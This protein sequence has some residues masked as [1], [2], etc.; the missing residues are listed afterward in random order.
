MSPS[1]HHHDERHHLGLEAD[2][3][4]L[5][6]RRRAL[7]LLGGAGLAALVGC[8]GDDGA[9]G[10]PSSTGAPS[11]TAA[12]ST[13]AA[14]P[15]CGDP[16][17]E[18]TEGPFPGDGSN[19]PSALEDSG[20]VRSDIRSSFGGATGVAEGVELRLQLSIFSATTCEQLPGAAVYVWQCDREGRYSMYDPAIA[21]ENY[22]RGVQGSAL[23]GTVLFTTIF[24][25]CYPGRWPHIHFEVYPSLSSITSP[26]N[27]LATSQLALPRDVCEEVYAEPGYERSAGH[28]EG[29]T[30]E[31]DTVFRD[32]HTTQLATVTGGHGHSLLAS[33]IIP[34]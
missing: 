23:D 18:E 11:S 3:P 13:T 9:G 14:R 27:K 19:G 24:P 16:I 12:P 25:A 20:V 1:P 15:D 34:V 28:L 10:D 7:Q 26:A 8:S 33:L 31:Q 6:G 32:G 30:I 22:L 29:L 17:P 2:L 5:L 21:H 4:R